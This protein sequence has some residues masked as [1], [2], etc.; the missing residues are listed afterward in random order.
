MRLKRSFSLLVE[1]VLDSPWSGSFQFLL[2]YTCR[3]RCS[4]L[5]EIASRSDVCLRRYASPNPCTYLVVASSS[6]QR[7]RRCK[8]ALALGSLEFSTEGATEQEVRT[9]Q[10]TFPQFDK[11]VPSSAAKLAQKMVGSKLVYTEI[12]TYPQNKS[13]RTVLS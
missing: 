10:T 13:S 3:L 6:T 11:Y 4:S 9:R 8:Q 5:N 2:T 12:L 7:C 1:R